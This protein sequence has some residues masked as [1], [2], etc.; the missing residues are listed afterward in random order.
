MKVKGTITRVEDIF[1]NLSTQD[2]WSRTG[3]KIKQWDNCF[4]LVD[5][6]LEF[7]QEGYTLQIW[8]KALATK[9]QY[10][11]NGDTIPLKIHDER[12]HDYQNK[13]VSNIMLMNNVGVFNQQR[14]GKTPT[15]LIAVREKKF[16]KTIITMKA[17]LLLQWKEE[18][19]KWLGYD[20]IVVN[21]PPKKRVAIYDNF[22]NSNKEEILLVSYDTLKLDWLLLQDTEYD[23]LIVDEADFIRNRSKRKENLLKVRQKCKYCW[24]LTGTPTVNGKH[25]I[26]PLISFM[27]PKVVMYRLYDYFFFKGIQRFGKSKKN[28]ER[29]KTN[30][31]FQESLGIVLQQWL[32]LFTL[33]T[34]RE[35]VWNLIPPVK[36][37]VVHVPMGEKQKKHYYDIL[38]FYV[39]GSEGNEIVAKGILAIITRLRQIMLDP[40]IIEDLNSTIVGAK[41]KQITQYVKDFHQ[42]KK[43]IIFADYTKYLNLLSEEF[44][45]IKIK[46]GLFTGEVKNN[47][48]N[49]VKHSF[50]DG[51]LNVILVN[52]EAGAK[53]L[54]LSSGDVIIF[55]QNSYSYILREQAMD[56]FIAQDDRPREVIDYICEYSDNIEENIEEAILDIQKFKR[57]QTDLVNN[58]KKILTKIRNKNK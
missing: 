3:I 55:A 21:Q 15:V 37:T 9:I 42:T 18:I 10:N 8:L 19:Q 44:T 39:T 33:N 52:T 36:E 14:T 23:C 35:E 40:R 7:L 31:I 45:K 16:K 5:S 26:I 50:Q 46:T 17:S 22:K 13:S 51:D 47:Q 58:W 2:S 54:T 6:T 32:E 53:G 57:N 27:Y 24:L 48:R 41:T 4:P 34:K 30:Y 28:K 38:N 29:I 56:R 1:Y 43:I 49:V 20:P 25:D 11:N 12:L